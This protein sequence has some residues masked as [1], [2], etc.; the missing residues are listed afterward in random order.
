MRTIFYTLI[1]AFF[2]TQATSQIVITEISYNPPESGADSLEYI[3]IYNAGTAAVSLVDYRFTKGITYTFPD[4]MINGGAYMLVVKNTNSFFNAY[5]ITALGWSADPLSGNAL[6]NGG[7]PVEISDAAGNVVIGFTYSRLAPWPTFADGTDGNGRSIE[8]CNPLAD[9]N[10]GNNWKVSENDLGFEING[11]QIFGTPGAAN[12]IPPCGST[13]DVTVEVSSFMFSPKD[14][15]IDVGDV[16]RW[17]N[18]GGTHNV[19]G[20]Q[21]VYPNNPESFFSGEPSSDAWTYDFKFNVAGV[22]TYQCDLHASL[23]MVGSV[24]VIGDV[25]IDQY[26]LRTIVEVTTTNQDGVAD[27]LNINCKL[28]G[29]V[30]GVNMRTP[31]LQFTIIDDQNNG[32]GMFSTSDFGYLVNEGDFI[33]A[34]GQ[35]TQFNGL[36]QMNIVAIKYLSD[37]TNNLLSPKMVTEFV[38]DDESS[39]ISVTN[40]TYVD[41]SQWTGTGAGFNLTM[42]NGFD[43][44]I[45]RIDNDVDVYNMPIIMPTAGSSLQIAGLLGQFDPTLPYTSGY[46]LLPRYVADFIITNSSYDLKLDSDVNIMPNPVNDLVKVQ[47]E[48]QIDYISVYNTSGQLLQTL[49]NQNQVDMSLHAKGLYM[50]HIGQGD[51]VSIRKLLKM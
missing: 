41:P 50:L 8:L 48:F 4:T 9:P 23:G 40:L 3:E 34:D 12:S 20:N 21:S 51:K 37:N 32:I 38:E 24:T 30:Y 26:P 1:F 31:G 14:I 16:V 36:T 29:T 44:F 6:N 22:Y 46:Q 43:E 2:F 45:I 15:T 10:D 47:S 11:K 27:S 7:E 49:Y 42:T 18:N 25:I 5:G 28:R 39:L 17:V 13:A 35:I 19:N 33:E